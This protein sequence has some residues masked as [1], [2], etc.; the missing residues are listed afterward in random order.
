MILTCECESTIHGYDSDNH[1]LIILNILRMIHWLLY[2]NFSGDIAVWYRRKRN[3]TSVLEKYSF[4]V[5]LRLSTHCSSGLFH[6]GLLGCR[7]IFIKWAGC[8]DVVSNLKIK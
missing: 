2:S 6:F 3:K 4:R 8:T 1:Y 7:N 5:W